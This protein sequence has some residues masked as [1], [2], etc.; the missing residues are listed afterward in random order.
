MLG[1]LPGSVSLDLIFHCRDTE[2]LFCLILLSF[3][4]LQFFRFIFHRTNTTRTTQFSLIP[5]T[6]ST[7]FIHNSSCRR[8]I[9][10]FMY[11]LFLWFVFF[12]F[13]FKL[14]FLN[15]C[16]RHSISTTIHTGGYAEQTHWTTRTFRETN[17]FFRQFF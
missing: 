9:R 10:W 16:A 6:H 14:E 4:L 1:V 11:I 12:L 17:I 13:F 3:E 2:V 15:I 8:H 7:N 5:C